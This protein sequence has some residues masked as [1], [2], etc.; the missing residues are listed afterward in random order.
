MKGFADTCLQYLVY[1]GYCAVT[2][3]AGAVPLRACD[4]LGKSCG[5][6]AWVVAV[7]YRRLARRNL[8][9]AFAGEHDEVWIRDVTRRQFEAIGRNFLIS[10]KLTA[11]PPE[12]IQDLVVYE[13]HEHVL[14]AIARGK[15]VIVAISHLGPWE[16]YSQLAKL[17]PGVP[18][19]TMYRPLGNR[20]INA[21]VVG[22][23][24][25]FGVALFDKSTGVYGPMKHLRDGGGL[26][27]LLDQHAG[28]LGIWSPFLGRL[29]STTNLPA[30]LSLRTGAPVV[31]ASFL[32]DGP[33]RWKVF[34]QPPHFP[35]EKPGPLAEEAARIT[36]ALNADLE[37]AIRRAPQEWFWLHNRWKTPK[38]A[39]LLGQ[40]KRGLH[41]PAGSA[42]KLK[43]FRVVL[44]SPNPLGD[45]CMAM[46]AVRAMKASRPDLHL[47]V[48]C[49]ENLGPIW[50]QCPEVDAILTVP[51]K[52]R[53]RAV[54]RLLRAQPAYEA[55]ILLP[56]SLSAA[57]EARHGRIPR[58]VGLRGH[59]RR[60]L[61]HQIVPPLSPGPPRHHA[62]T[63]LHLAE[64]IGADIT[65]E[66]V[67]IN[68]PAPQ[69]FSK[70]RQSPPHVG[71][72][73]G[74]EYGA[75]KRWPEDRFAAAADRIRRA[76]GCRLT[77]FGSPAEREIGEKI[78]AALGGNCDNRVG[79]TTIQG[80]IDELRGCD[81]LLTNDTGTMHL[82][83]MLGIPTVAVFG[84]TE[85]DWTRPLG[86]GHRV[87]RHKVECSPCFLRECPRDFRCMTGIDAETV[88]CEA[89]EILK[90]NASY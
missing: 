83:A 59:W 17:C 68:H 30:L 13:C 66:A 52:A 79:S 35:P 65:A 4:W 51:K 82:A 85:P 22:Q 71:I 75:A 26:G 53:P 56:N 1:L 19:A 41:L 57:L 46:P 58:I 12:K 48:L 23:R 15:G 88:A 25:R 90:A 72:C 16:L 43:K 33:R 6:L 87:V 9:I 11:I 34:Y 80:L 73:P 40:S 5:W 78:A 20:F 44:R 61:L 7:P 21:S 18:N 8:R 37:T 32:P 49:R 67:A 10:L 28:D 39:F 29:A 38:P 86:A 50:R 89:I 63:Y 14:A 45:A 3:L 84:S 76:T 55:A 47:T 81:L 64:H 31:T 36:A 42:E 77:L 70:N 2:A 27:I 60:W 24:A 54:G 69:P 62:H 74:A